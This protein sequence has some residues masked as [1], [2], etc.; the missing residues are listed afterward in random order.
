MEA[1]NQSLFGKH[2]LL[3][4]MI[5]LPPLPG[6]PMYAGQD[7]D[8][9]IQHGQEDLAML[10]EGGIRSILIE[11]FGDAPYSRYKIPRETL[12][13][14]AIVS[15]DIIR[16]G[17]QKLKVVGINVLRNDWESAISIA[18]AVRA[19]FIRL[20][21]LTGVAITDQG[22][23]QGEAFE[24]LNFKKQV[25]PNVKIF[26]DVLVKHSY[27]LLVDSERILD[28]IVK[29]T[30]DRGQADAIIVSGTRTGS[31]PDK[32]LI[33]RVTQAVPNT[34]V[35]I[36]SGLSFRNAPELLQLTAG[37]IVGTSLKNKGKIDVGKVK[38]LVNI[39]KKV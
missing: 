38:E 21:V 7:I 10:L 14:M 17:G 11:N 4:G 24:C 13:A 32:E 9:I 6:S 18:S 3:I 37:A 33:R 20:N 5:H 36:G 2:K 15:R 31:E 27:P 1:V 34:A 29:D 22:L 12:T 16:A 8:Q 35:L 25:A 23:V 19:D 28:D 26:A 30:V 39:A